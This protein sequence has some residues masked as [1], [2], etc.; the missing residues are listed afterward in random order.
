MQRCVHAMGPWGGWVALVAVGCAASR[1]DEQMVGS[2]PISGLPDDA[3][4]GSADGDGPSGGVA[5]ATAAA[6]LDVGDAMATGNAADN[7]EDCEQDI[8]VVFVMDVS[9][10]M[11]PFLAKLADEILVVDQAIAELGLPNPPHYGLVAFVDD[12]AILN[13]GTS[14]ADVETLRADFESWSSFTATNEQVGGGNHNSTWPE[15]SLDGLFLAAA[16]FQWRPQG[17]TTLRMIIH[18]TDDTFWNGPTQGN[19]VPVTDS[20]DDVVGALQERQIRMFSFAAQ[21]GGQCEC[22][23]VTPGWS[24]PFEG[25]PALP[26]STDGAVFDIDLVLSGQLSLADAINGVIEEKMC[27]PY[28]PAG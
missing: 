13:A 16:E 21:I 18:T 19:G 11:G 20:F 28:P 24:S 23:D 5:D 4:A 7:G 27:D 26:E 25:K 1:S 17:D 10:S 6:V 3:S 14:Y 15:N 22:E 12:A 2:T 9:T 8:D